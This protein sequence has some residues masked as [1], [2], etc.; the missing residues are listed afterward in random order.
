[1]GAPEEHVHRQ[2]V[3]TR[4]YSERTRH[5]KT[6]AGETSNDNVNRRR[7]ADEPLRMG[8]DIPVQRDLR[9]GAMP[10]VIADGGNPRSS[11]IPGANNIYS[12][13]D[14]A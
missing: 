6:I 5:W 9:L 4:P 10:N 1:M 11:G 13:D 12:R 7:A 2:P 14:T 3:L 8:Q